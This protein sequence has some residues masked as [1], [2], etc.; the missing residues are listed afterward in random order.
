M[1]EQSSLL[2]SLRKQLGSLSPDEV[3]AA[4]A[5]MKEREASAL[6]YDWPLWARPAQLLPPGDWFVWLILA[7]RGFGKT[8]T[9]AETVREWV[10]NFPIVNIAGPTAADARDVMVEGESGILSICSPDEMP[11]YIKSDRKLR[12]PNGSISL[13][14]SADEPE[15]FRGPQAYKLWADEIAAWRYPEAWDQAMFGLRLGKKPQAVVTTTPKPIKLVRSLLASP[16]TH[17]TRGRTYDNRANL[18]ESFFTQIITKYEGTRLGRQEL[19]A[20]VLED[21]PGALFSRDNID[22]NRVMKAPEDLQ[23]IVIPIDPAVTANENSD[24]TGIVPVG[25]DRRSPPHF[26]IL[27]DESLK[28]SPDGWAQVAVA[29][30]KRYRA[31]RIIAEAN[32]GGDMVEA[33]IRH[34]DA[35]V[36][37]SKVT[38]TRGKT[39]RAEPIAALY[40]QD[41]VHHVGCFPELE[42]QMCEWNPQIPDE[43]QDSPDRMDALVWG[44]TELSAVADGVLNYYAAKAETKKRD[45]VPTVLPKDARKW[46]EPVRLVAMGIQ[47]EIAKENWITFGAELTEWSELVASKEQRKFSD[48]VIS[49]LE[50][51]FG[52]ITVEI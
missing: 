18:A 33:V 9:G 34:K 39:R 22:K 47:P 49:A 44:L 1:Q 41:R 25:M 29:S 8:R 28:A 19:E 45:E 13:I 12:W 24:E 11:T 20:E 48:K 32:N 21:N 51:K 26:Y 35:N 42:D 17:V 50:K 6:L 46:S 5:G 40:E 36:P 7:G 30:F 31:D 15:R 43:Q 10:K 3:T 4:I 52:K 14:F 38:A 23:R 27:G 16:T 2:D 37:F